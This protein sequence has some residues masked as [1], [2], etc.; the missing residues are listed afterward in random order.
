MPVYEERR[1]IWRH[2][3]PVRRIMPKHESKLS[4]LCRGTDKLRLFAQNA[5]WIALL[6][7]T[8]SLSNQSTRWTISTVVRTR[9]MGYAKEALVIL[10]IQNIILTTIFGPL[11]TARHML[12]SFWLLT[13]LFYIQFSR[14]TEITYGRETRHMVMRRLYIYTYMYICYIV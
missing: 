7:W 10:Q 12:I 11:R 4:S 1:D 14:R 6:W 3:F 2:L 9:N 5:F 13:R 8:I